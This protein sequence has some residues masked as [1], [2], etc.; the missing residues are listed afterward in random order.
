MVLSKWSSLAGR[1]DPEEGEV[2]V[3]AIPVVQLLPWLPGIIPFS[4]SKRYNLSLRWKFSLLSSLFCDSTSLREVTDW[5]LER[6]QPRVDDDEGRGPTLSSSWRRLWGR[7]RVFVTKG[8]F[9]ASSC[10]L[11]ELLKEGRENVSSSSISSSSSSLNESSSSSSLYF[12]RKLR[13]K[14]PC[15]F[16]LPLIVSKYVYRLIVEKNM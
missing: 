8:C 3:E 15:P 5:L 10:C 16:D 9:T 7:V 4:F 14:S 11:T 1:D 13:V 12:S 6:L 2:G